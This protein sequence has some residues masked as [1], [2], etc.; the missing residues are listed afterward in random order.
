MQP[1][2]PPDSISSSA[3]INAHP[4]LLAGDDDEDEPPATRRRVSGPIRRRDF[5]ITYHA[6]T[7]PIA[8]LKELHAAGKLVYA[9]YQRELTRDGGMHWQAFL[10]FSNPTSI[11]F[12]KDDI[13]A[14]PRVH[15][16][17][18]REKKEYA[19][20]YCMKKKTRVPGTSYEEIGKPTEQGKRTD[21]QL[22]KEAIDDGQTMS[23]VVEENFDIAAK[24]SNGLKMYAAV[25]AQQRSMAERNIEVRVY[26]GKTGTG[27]TRLAVDECKALI[28]G[29]APNVFILDPPS[30]GGRIWWC[31]YE[32]QKGIIIDEWNCKIPITTLLRMLDRYPYKCEIK[33]GHTYALW[34][35]VWITTNI[36]LAEWTDCGKPI[37]KAHA[38]ALDRRITHVIQF[39]KNGETIVH[40]APGTKSKQES[41]DDE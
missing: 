40:K 19:R 32:G 6:E 28:G 35:H 41:S 12:V 14:D 3:P 16:E 5:C 29:D 27:K 9:I 2:I 31:G 18:R 8:K 13:F 7:F 22:V 24:Y 23:T 20:W 34:T 11:P 17:I 37:Q 4:G 26:Y 36:P 21:L 33:G 25:K 10:E 39:K 30:E 15:V 1:S 38:R